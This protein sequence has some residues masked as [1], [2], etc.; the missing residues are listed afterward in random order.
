MRQVVCVA[1]VVLLFATTPVAAASGDADPGPTHIVIG[2]DVHQNGDATWNVTATYPLN[3]SSERRAFARLSDQFTRGD[4]VFVQPRVFEAAASTA[5]QQTN[6]PMSITDV[7]RSTAVRN[8]T[9]VNATGVLTLRFRWN[10]FA[11]VRNGNIT[12]GDAF[13]TGLLGD[14]TA[15][16]TMY[17]VP[18]DG[19][20]LSSV[21]SSEQVRNGVIY[22]DG[23]YEFARGGPHVQFTE[24]P[25][26]PFGTLGGIAALVVAALVAGGAA[27]YVFARRSER[28]IPTLGGRRGEAEHGREAPPEEAE[29]APAAEPEPEPE[30][31]SESASAAGGVDDELLSDEERVE[32]LLEEHG[33]RMKQA[34]IVEETRWSNAKVSQ[35]LSSMAEDGRVEKLRIGRENLI[36]LPEDE[37]EE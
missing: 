20:Q 25:D 6:R 4:D 29:R 16:E 23:P 28:G 19:Y 14:L 3:S 1:L 18:P 12:V 34:K 31:E 11:N 32:R 21:S 37:T 8:H 33:G 15:R 7:R 5:S 36:S 17:L 2:I 10:G 24:A 27:A 26:S 22:W 30:P 35:L 9:G 13:T